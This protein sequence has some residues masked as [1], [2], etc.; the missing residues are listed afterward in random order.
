M[1]MT[2]ATWTYIT[3]IVIECNL[4]YQY[5]FFCVAHSEIL[6][7]TNS[8]HISSY[9]ASSHYVL[10]TNFIILSLNTCH[11]KHMQNVAK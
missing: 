9:V 7:N 2:Y 1:I 3:V 11:H 10:I 5:V 8:V 4:S 6:R